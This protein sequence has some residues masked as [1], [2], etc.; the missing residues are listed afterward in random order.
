MTLASEAAQVLM[1]ASQQAQESAET[2][3]DREREVLKPMVE[4]LN[5]AEIAERPVESLSTVKYHISNILGKMGVDNR[6][7]AVTAAIQKKLV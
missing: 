6:V 4:D 5:N 1:R 2:L 3:T 7:A